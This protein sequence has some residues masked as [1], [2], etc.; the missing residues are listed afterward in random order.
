MYLPGQSTFVGQLAVEARYDD[1]DAHSQLGVHR[2]LDVL[3]EEVQHVL[4]HGG[5]LLQDLLQ[6]ADHA[7]LEGDLPLLA[8]TVVEELDHHGQLVGELVHDQQTVGHHALL[9]QVGH[10]VH[11]LE[12]LVQQ[13]LDARLVDD[14]DHDRDHQRNHHFAL[15]VQQIVEERLA[16]EQGE[17]VRVADDELEHLQGLEVGDGVV[18]PLE[19]FSQLPHEG[20]H[21]RVV[22]VFHERQHARALDFDHVALPVEGQLQEEQH[23]LEQSP[24]RLLGAQDQTGARLQHLQKREAAHFLHDLAIAFRDMLQKVR[25]ILQKHDVLGVAH[26]EQHVEGDVG[27][28]SQIAVAQQRLE[29]HR[30]LLDQLLVAGLLDLIQSHQRRLD[31]LGILVDQVVFEHPLNLDRVLGAHEHGQHAQGIH[32]RVERGARGDVLGHRVGHHVQRVFFFQVSQV[33]RQQFL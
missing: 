12:D 29:L 14:F 6:D 27:D 33:N 20:L 18:V 25:K 3:T 21:R 19:Q 10:V 26:V 9:D 31:H 23:A 1:D 30:A 28:V 13:P 32:L 5:V 11:D 2:V 15:R 24:V 7:Q 4:G 17:S 16:L 8:E 22:H